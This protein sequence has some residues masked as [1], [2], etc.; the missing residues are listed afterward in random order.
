MWW[1]IGP[2]GGGTVLAI[3]IIA[4]SVTDNPA[5]LRGLTDAAL[6]RCEINE[7]LAE[8]LYNAVDNPDDKRILDLLV[9]GKAVQA[10]DVRGVDDRIKNSAATPIVWD[11][12]CY[13]ADR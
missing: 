3:V 1:L 13:I 2:I 11:A 8:I 5:I 12:I 6:V 4:L 7:R 10:S 9:L